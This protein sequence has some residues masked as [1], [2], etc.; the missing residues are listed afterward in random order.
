MIEK[1]EKYAQVAASY[2]FFLGWR[3]GVLAGYIA[4]VCAALSLF[5]SFLTSAPAGASWL[6]LVV[7][8]VG[9]L[10]YLFDAKNREM[11]YVALEAGRK[12]EEGSG[13]YTD[14]DGVHARTSGDPCD[15]N[16]LNSLMAP[17][18]FLGGS[19]IVLLIG[20]GSFVRH[21]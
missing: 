18:V 12:L 13:I 1:N 9:I 3:L 2:R 17:S 11:I 15:L 7:S 16:T 20:I 5:S 10:F 21:A 19:L 14:L 4:I 8:P 6:M